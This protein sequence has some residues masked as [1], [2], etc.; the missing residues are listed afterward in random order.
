MPLPSP[1]NI[2]RWVGAVI[3]T[4]IDF[5]ATEVLLYKVEWHLH[6]SYRASGNIQKMVT[7]GN[8]YHPLFFSAIEKLFVAHSYMDN[9]P[10]SI[11]VG[12]KKGNYKL[13]LT[14]A[15]IDTITIALE[16]QPLN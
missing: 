5:D 14:R 15:E 1:D 9:A 2:R 6:I 10:L 3:S 16:R 11:N 4:A 8:M 13:T 7:M 12:H